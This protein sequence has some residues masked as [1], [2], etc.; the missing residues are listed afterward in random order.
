MKT[1]VLQYKFPEIYNRQAHK[2]LWRDWCVS[3]SINKIRKTKDK[4]KHTCY[5]MRVIERVETILTDI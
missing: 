3:K 5:R 2:Q 1:L 4:F